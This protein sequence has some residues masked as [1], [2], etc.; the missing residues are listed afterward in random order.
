[1]RKGQRKFKASIEPPFVLQIP[2]ISVD[3]VVV[4]GVEEDD[5]KKG[6]GGI[7]EACF[8]E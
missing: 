5:L 7:L 6:Q 8:R 1:M 2:A 4:E 3:A